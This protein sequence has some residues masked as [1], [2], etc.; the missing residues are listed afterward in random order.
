MQFSL[1]DIAKKNVLAVQ[2][3]SLLAWASIANIFSSPRYLADTIQQADIIG[4]G[5]LPIVVLTGFFLG[6]VLA[7]QSANSLARFGGLSFTGQLVSL[8]MV[9][10][11]GPV[12]TGLMVA[13]RSATGM[14]SEL[15]SMQVTEQIDAMRALGTDPSKK[16]V[17][18]RVVSTVVMLVMLT[19]ISD[20]VSM[21]G[22][23]AVAVFMLRL[24]GN[25]YWSTAWQSLGTGDII[26]GLLKP[27]IF[28]FIISTIGCYYGISA[29]GGTQGV[30]RATTQAMVSASVTMVI[31]DLFI[32]QLLLNFFPYK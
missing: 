15:G 25:Q 20:L 4:V 21:A 18:P 7:L 2:E 23:S 31:A 29:R 16:L 10:E 30:G 32:T 3:Y 24:D 22:G 8:S 19:V 6:A 27:F 17:T 1:T 26:M 28:G 9:R 14:A 12:L 5:S 13:G 11:I